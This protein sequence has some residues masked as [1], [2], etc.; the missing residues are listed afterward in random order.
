[1]A[2]LLKVS[3]NTILAAYDEL[4]ADGLIRGE[5][6]AGMRVVGAVP[7]LTLAGLRGVIR[8]AGYPARVVAFTDADGNVLYLR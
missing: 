1:M 8:A 4:A 2:G 6:G 7:A 3:R 5:R